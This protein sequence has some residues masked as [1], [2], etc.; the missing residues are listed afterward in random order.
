MGMTNKVPVALGIALLVVGLAA[1]QKKT[2]EE[3]GHDLTADKA[4]YV[5]GVG[6][7]L[8]NEGEQAA[9]SLGE[10]I[11]KIIKSGT[12]GVTGG[13][14][15]VDASAT[16][17]ASTHGLRLSKAERLSDK[18]AQDASAP[19][20]KKHMITA[21]IIADKDFS[22]KLRLVALGN[23]RAEIGRAALEL[24]LAAGEARYVDFAFDER[25]S[26]NDVKLVELEAL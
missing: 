6:E 4:N 25:M 11:G 26:F 23:K 7:G 18:A 9:Q 20:E 16:A 8:K 1:C 24:K 14:L 17:S 19:A 21:Y 15:A 5:K 3:K 10:G 12:S 22:G 2:E 13:L